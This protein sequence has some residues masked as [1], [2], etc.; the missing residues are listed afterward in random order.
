MM[1]ALQNAIRW[2][3][4]YK[5]RVTSLEDDPVEAIIGFV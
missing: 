3:L 1:V 5:R 4:P 2:A